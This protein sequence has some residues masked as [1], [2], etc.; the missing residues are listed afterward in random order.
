MSAECIPPGEAAVE[1]Q[2]LWLLWRES[3][4]RRPEENGMEE[5]RVSSGAH[6]LSIPPQVPISFP[7][8]FEWIFC[9]RRPP[10]HVSWLY[11]GI[12]RN[13]RIA[14][15]DDKDLLLPLGHLPPVYLF[16][17]CSIR[18]ALTMSAHKQIV[19]PRRLLLQHT[20]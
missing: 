11:A 10:P 14:P 16:I 7:G 1:R 18:L 19:N 9:A 12:L 15:F 3:P 20:T 5:G 4:P 13:P 17:F 8:D 6:F 2:S